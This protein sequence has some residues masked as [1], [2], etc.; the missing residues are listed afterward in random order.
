MVTMMADKDFDLATVASAADEV[1]LLPLAEDA[2]DKRSLL[3]AI[4]AGASGFI[5]STRP[6]APKERREEL[7][8]VMLL[9]EACADADALPIALLLCPS[10]RAAELP[11]RITVVPPPIVPSSLLSAVRMRQTRNKK[12]PSGNPM[13]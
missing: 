12:E 11:A 9:V 10:T 5:L 4:R 13:T 8:V 6:P 2:D 1:L 3:L 7:L